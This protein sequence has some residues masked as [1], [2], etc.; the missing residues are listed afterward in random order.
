MWKEACVVVYPKLCL[1]TGV[2]RC[3]VIQVVNRS[4]ETA[5]VSKRSPSGR[6]CW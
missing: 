2:Y 4:R 1:G 5:R 3:E 6:K